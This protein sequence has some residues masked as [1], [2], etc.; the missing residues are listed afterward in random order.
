MITTKFGSRYRK[1]VM[2]TVNVHSEH[3]TTHASGDVC[4]MNTVQSLGER[5]QTRCTT[6]S[7]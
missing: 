3:R 5:G 4:V 1:A 6:T 7:L 2:Y